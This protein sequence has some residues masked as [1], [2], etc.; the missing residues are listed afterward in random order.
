MKKLPIFFFVFLGFL[1]IAQNPD[2]S[3]VPSSYIQEWQKAGIDSS[4]FLNVVNHSIHDIQ[5]DTI[6]GEYY[7]IA[8]EINSFLSSLDTTVHHH[9]EFEAAHYH[10][11]N[12]SVAINIGSNTSF[13]GKGANATFLHFT[14]LNN[15]FVHV[16]RCTGNQIGLSYF[17]IDLNNFYSGISPDTDTAEIASANRSAIAIFESSNVVIL[18]VHIER[19]L[20]AHVNISK[21]NYVWVHGCYF[22]DAWLHGNH[23]NYGTQ[24]YGVVFGGNDTE[25]SSY[26]LIEN[27]IIENC[28]HAIVCQYYAQYNV[29]AYNYTR[30]SY[31]YNFIGNDKYDWITS[32][33]VMHG[34][35]ANYNLIEGNVFEA[36]TTVGR[37]GLTIDKVKTIGNGI[38]NTYYRN[39]SAEALRLEIK[40][41]DYNQQQLLIDNQSP[42]IDIEGKLHTLFNNADLQG[43]LVSDVGE[44]CVNQQTIINNQSTN[45]GY[46]CYLQAN[47]CWINQNQLPFIGL[48][49]QYATNPAHYRFLLVQLSI[50]SFTCQNNEIPT[51][52]V[53]YFPIE[54]FSMYPNP[55]KDKITFFK[56]DDKALLLK[57]FNPLGQCVFDTNWEKNHKEIYWPSTLKDGVYIVNVY[58]QEELVFSNQIIIQK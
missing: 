37:Y 56:I 2:P 22:N 27:N 32:D 57:V 25:F 33:L 19:G 24:G 26:C 46:T 10:I 3:I 53:C 8:S 30:N 54:D 9:I 35:G 20:G 13:Q 28:R 21:S 43:D 18:G 51:P 47:D 34:N 17:N 42:V 55:S 14:A 40:N 16:F 48:S 15:S 44:E 29:I 38:Q 58:N 31:A 45:T 6:N 36:S 52:I 7:F 5:H 1:L 41:C 49:K 50:D 12:D 23:L 11:L 4:Q 39:F